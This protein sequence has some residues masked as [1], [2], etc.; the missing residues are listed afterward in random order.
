[1]TVLVIGASGFVGQHVLSA[2]DR[3]RSARVPYAVARARLRFTPALGRWTESSAHRLHLLAS[4]HTFDAS[5]TTGVLGPLDD[6]RGFAAR[7]E[8]CA[9]WYRKELA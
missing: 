4:D 9:S 6:P 3:P 1:M 2:L 7:F 8:R 5:R